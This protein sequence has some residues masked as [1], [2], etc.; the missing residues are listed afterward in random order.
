[1]Y[2]TVQDIVINIL[3][4]CPA[5]D[6][7]WRDNHCSIL[8]QWSAFTAAQ[9]NQM[10]LILVIL[11][12]LYTLYYGGRERSARCNFRKHMQIEKAPANQENIFIILTADGTNPHKYILFAARFFFWL[13]CEHVQRV[14]CQIEV[15]FDL[16][17]NCQVV[18]L[19][20]MC[21]LKLQ[22]VE[23]SRPP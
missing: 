10:H 7:C 2:L 6:A 11:V 20:Y 8:L 1:M 22:R 5:C 4:V 3:V 13:C 23:L 18:S 14:C 16:R 9:L 17:S 19:I 12:S 15:W 21:F